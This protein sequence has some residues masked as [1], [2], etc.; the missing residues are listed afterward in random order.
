M[1]VPLSSRP[2][3]TNSTTTS[4]H[5]HTPPLQ[6]TITAAPAAVVGKVTLESVP[7]PIAAAAEG[8]KEPHLPP[9]GTYFERNRPGTGNNNGNR[10]LEEAVKQDDAAAS[11]VDG[12]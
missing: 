1:Y 9:P 5:S 8:D 10:V 7:S 6:P 12:A 4:L 2:L 11:A 3:H